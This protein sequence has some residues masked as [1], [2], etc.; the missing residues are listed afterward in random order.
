MKRIYLILLSFIVLTVTASAQLRMPAAMSD[1]M[2]LQQSGTANIWG[3]ATPNSSVTVTTSWNGKSTKVQAN[4]VGEWTAS[5]ETP[6]G[7]YTPYSI[8]VREGKGQPVEIN[9]VLIG[10]VWVCSGQSNMYMQM[11]G[12][13]NQPVDNSLPAILESGMYR[14]KVR[15]LTVPCNASAKPEVDFK[16]R[17]E[18]ASPA[19]TPEFSAAAYF[20]ARTLTNV[21]DVPVG[22]ISTS[23]GGSAIEAWIDKANITRVEGADV[24]A[25]ESNK[26]AVNQ[27]LGMLYN[28]L[29][30]P[31]QKYTARGFL[32]Y[33]GESNR[34]N[35]KQYADL[36]AVMVDFWRKQW[37]NDA[38]P[39]YSAQIAPFSYGNS[40]DI[41]GS[42]LIEA[43]IKASKITPNSSII[44]LTDIGDEWCIHPPQKDIVGFRFANLALVDCYKVNPKLPKTGPMMT[45]V[46]FGPDKTVVTFDNIPTGLTSHNRP[47]IGFEMAGEDKVFYPAQAKIGKTSVVEVTCDKVLKPVA[48]RYAFRNNME[49]NLCNTYGLAAFPFRTDTWDDVK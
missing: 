20:F 33:Q 1:N 2:V 44:T 5:V 27:R 22:I 29:I 15:F 42:L 24:A 41:S 49:A 12:Y 9:N 48:L 10:E 32:W 30:Y 23:W 28:G 35:Y 14:N 43:Q 40:R 6:V 4:S 16:G 39:F 31:I 7:S 17:W 26:R 36:T 46:E 34:N 3:W 45:K 37:G 47:I 13:N 19:T 21:L 18:V 38:M 25:L 11:R 8:S